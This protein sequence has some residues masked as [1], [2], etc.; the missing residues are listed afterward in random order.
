MLDHVVVGPV[1][2]ICIPALI[3]HET[4]HLVHYDMYFISNFINNKSVTFEERRKNVELILQTG[5]E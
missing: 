4:I 2:D 5:L 1:V 3:M